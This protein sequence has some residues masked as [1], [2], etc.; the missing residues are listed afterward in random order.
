MKITIKHI[1]YSV[2]FILVMG[3]SFQSY[4]LSVK[5]SKLNQSNIEL[6]NARRNALLYRDSI[7]MITLRNKQIQ[8]KIDSLGRVVID[9]RG[10][11]SILHRKLAIAL[12]KI[13]SIPPEEN[14]TF[15]QDSAYAYP[16]DKVFKFNAT[17]VTEIRKTYAENI[18]LKKINVND[19]I[20]IQIMQEQSIVKDTL[21]HNLYGQ[22]SIYDNMIRSLDDTID[23]QAKENVNLNKKLIRSKRFV[24]FFEGTT[25]VG[26]IF[27]I[28]SLI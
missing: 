4:R 9:L 3:L 27:I 24:Y 7:N 19:A 28:I 18:I 21:I 1:A 14:Y 11:T 20:T 17:Q 6:V 16:G 13:D 26:V 5:M 25:A 12:S 22:I 8:R 10:A 23:K 15:L 2:I